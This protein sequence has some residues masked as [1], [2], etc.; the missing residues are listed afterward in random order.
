[1]TITPSKP[2]RSETQT[3]LFHRLFGSDSDSD[4]EDDPSPALDVEAFD[5]ASI[6]IEGTEYLHCAATNLVYDL[7]TQQQL[8]KLSSEGR[9]VGC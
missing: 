1:M 4:P 3:E 8:G 5:V 2:A 6:F 9:L 7:H